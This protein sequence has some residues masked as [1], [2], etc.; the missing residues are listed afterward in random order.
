MKRYRLILI[1]LIVIT[2]MSCKKDIVVTCPP[3]NHYNLSSFT[4]QFAFKKNSYW[5]LKNNTTNIKDTLKMY[6]NSGIINS[7]HS[8]ASK[9]C[10]NGDVYEEYDESMYHSML[11]GGSQGIDLYGS[12]NGLKI[13]SYPKYNVSPLAIVSAIGDSIIYNSNTFWCK[14]EAIYPNL[15][16]NNNSYSNVY[17][18]FY[19]PDLYGFKRIWWCPTIGFI[20]F[21][22]FN[23]ITNLTEYWEL[24]SYNVQLY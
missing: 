11:P 8:G 17:Q 19:Y 14:L 9:E 4:K 15:I 16:I 1:C 6:F 2:T 12:L 22:N 10:P 3:Q 13:Q 23:T 5:V 24:D 20:K 18:M 21:E 7:N